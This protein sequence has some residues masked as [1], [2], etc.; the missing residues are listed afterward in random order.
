MVKYFY[1]ILMFKYMCFLLHRLGK[2]V[3]HFLPQNSLLIIPQKL[4]VCIKNKIICTVSHT[5]LSKVDENLLYSAPLPLHQ[6]GEKC[7][8]M[9]RPAREATTLLTST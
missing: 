5:T 7:L 9:F 1:F 4:T 6:C 8:D 3:K 2:L